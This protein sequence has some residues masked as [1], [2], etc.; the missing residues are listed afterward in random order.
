MQRIFFS[1]LLLATFLSLSPAQAATRLTCKGVW[2]VLVELG[3]PHSTISVYKE[4]ARI[5]QWSGH[6]HFKLKD[7]IPQYNWYFHSE[8][9]EDVPAKELEAKLSGIGSDAKTGPAT[10]TFDRA[11]PPLR[12]NCVSN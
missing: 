5:D 2:T 10:Y 8:E 6:T 1:L 3:N 9:S 12:L 11:R 7:T 4:G